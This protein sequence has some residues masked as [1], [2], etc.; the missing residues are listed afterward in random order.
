MFCVDNQ[1]LSWDTVQK[2]QRQ[3]DTIDELPAVTFMKGT[4]L[5]NIEK[6]SVRTSR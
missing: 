3:A 4:D 6:R 2:I 5:V 1:N